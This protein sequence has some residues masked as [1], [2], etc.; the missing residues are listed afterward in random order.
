MRRWCT[1]RAVVAAVRR[2][3]A[4]WQ[5]RHLR[6]EVKRLRRDFARGAISADQYDRQLL[7]VA[8]RHMQMGGGQ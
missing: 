7:D 6:R 8:R 4:Q 2:A 5:C 3:R 1:T